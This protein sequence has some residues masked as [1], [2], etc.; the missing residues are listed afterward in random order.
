MIFLDRATGPDRLRLNTVWANSAS[1]ALRFDP[2]NEGFKRGIGGL[3]LEGEE[4][5]GEWLF[6]GAR[7]PPAERSDSS[8]LR[9]PPVPLY[10]IEPHTCTEHQ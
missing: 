3:A 9:S 4:H 1:S 7:R 8:P 2:K 5:Y 10:C 6:P